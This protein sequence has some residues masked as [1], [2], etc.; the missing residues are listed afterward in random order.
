MSKNK[1]PQITWG[2]SF[3]NTLN[4]GYPLDNWTAYSRPREGSQWSMGVSGLEDSWILGTDYILEG[5]IRWIPTND[6]VSPSATGW[7]GATGWR[8]FLE[9]AREKNIIRFYPDKS[10]GL[11]HECYL[12]SPMTEAPELEPDG[13]RRIRLSVRSTSGSF[14][15]Y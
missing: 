11:Y 13:T 3:T 6:T 12:V 14:N 7:D 2:T 5:D 4:I 9:Y 8:S 10:A 1:I 15:G